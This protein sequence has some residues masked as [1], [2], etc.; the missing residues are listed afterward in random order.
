[1]HPVTPPPPLSPPPPPPP[2]PVAPAPPAPASASAPLMSSS[3]E[4]ASPE[5]GL[6]L[7]HVDAVSG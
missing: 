2:A 7:E 5:R 4:G 6:G 3:I 1:M